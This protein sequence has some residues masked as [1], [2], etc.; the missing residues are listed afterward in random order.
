MSILI[1]NTYYTNISPVMTGISSPS[2]YVTECSIVCISQFYKALD[3]NIDSYFRTNIQTVTPFTISLDYGEGN[4]KVVSAYI[5]DCHYNVSFTMKSWNFEGSNDNNTWDILDSR[6]DI[7]WSGNAIQ[8]FTFDNSTKYRYYRFNILEKNSANSV[9]I[10]EIELLQEDPSTNLEFRKVRKNNL[11]SSKTDGIDTVYFTEDGE[12]YVTDK[13]GNL[14][15]SGVTKISTA[16][17][18][19]YTNVDYPAYTNV[20]LALD[21]LFNKVYYVKPT[22]S[23]SA[24]KAGGTFEMGTTITAPITFTWTTNKAITSQTLTGCTL[25][26]ASVR[27]ATYN[28]NVTS[29]KTFTLSVSDGENS[30]SSSVSYKFLNNVFWGSASTAETYD[31]A[32]ISALSNKKLASAVKGT[33]SFNIASGEYGFWAVP[34]NMTIS[35][36][37][38]GGFEV[39]VDD[40]GTVSYTNAQGYTRD[41]KLYKTGKASLGAISAEIK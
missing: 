3:G 25:A 10:N 4:E 23:L 20:D 22:C 30:A 14:K 38:I 34:S 11:P 17:T 19:T 2:P 28:T 24:S 37:W 35:S 8:N 7:S 39:T 41:Y 31:S 9:C 40:L 1:G 15:Q 6:S 27:T 26:D 29:D 33:Y 13:N 18:T 21:A 12:I 36:V 5:L 16:E 32:F